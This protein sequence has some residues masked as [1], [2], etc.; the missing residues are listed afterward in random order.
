MEV[1]SD[2]VLPCAS[3]ATGSWDRLALT[4]RSM[5]VVWPLRTF[6]LRPSLTVYRNLRLN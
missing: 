4:V 5:A 6:Q 2:S 1:E 3:N